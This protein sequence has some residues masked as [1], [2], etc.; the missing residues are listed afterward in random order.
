M[1][2]PAWRAVCR[3]CKAARSNAVA[4]ALLEV[5][6]GSD[7]VSYLSSNEWLQFW[8]DNAERVLAPGYVPTSEDMLK[9]RRPTA[10]M[11]ELPF[12]VNLHDTDMDFVLVD[13]GGQTHEMK[14]WGH[15]LEKPVERSQNT[16]A[17]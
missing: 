17:H 11:A 13:V 10:G 12:T 3:A 9:L 8:L 16:P 5:K 14:T 7:N 1:R 6:A 4:Q 2:L 15:E